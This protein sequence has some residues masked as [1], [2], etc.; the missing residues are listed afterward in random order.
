MKSLGSISWNLFLYILFESSSWDIWCK[1][2]SLQNPNSKLSAACL[3]PV[4]ASAADL[5][6]SD[7]PALPKQGREHPKLAFS[8]NSPI[9]LVKDCVCVVEQACP[10]GV[11]PQEEGGEGQDQDVARPGKKKFFF[12][13]VQFHLSLFIYIY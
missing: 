2:S 6:L 7:P 9:P 12:E 3:L 11:H 13:F 8:L 10:D 1:P 5:Q 4:T